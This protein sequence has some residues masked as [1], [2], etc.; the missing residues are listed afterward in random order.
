MVDF[1]ATNKDETKSEPISLD[2]LKKAMADAHPDHGGTNEAFIRARARYVAA[3]SGK[4]FYRARK[5]QKANSAKND[6][7]N[8]QERKQEAK[9]PKTGKQEEKKPTTKPHTFAH[10]KDIAIAAITIIGACILFFAV[11]NADITTTLPGGEGE[12]GNAHQQPQPTF[13]DRR[14]DVLQHS[15]WEAPWLNAFHRCD[16][17][18][19]VKDTESGVEIDHSQPATT[20]CSPTA[21]DELKT[22]AMLLEDDASDPNGHQFVGTAVWRTDRVAPGPGQAPELAIRADIEIP[23]QRISVK[24][25]L[26]RNDDKALPAS[27]TIEIVFTLPADFPHGSIANIPGVLMKQVESTRGIPLAG[28]AVKVTTN[29]FL[30]GLSSIDAD[31]QRNIQLLKERPWFD[32]PIVYGD[33]QRA[34]IAVEKGAPG[35]R[36]FAEAF[37]AWRFAPQ[38]YYWQAEIDI[39]PL[40]AQPPAAPLPLDSIVPLTPPPIEPP[41]TDSITPPKEEEKPVELNRPSGGVMPGTGGPFDSVGGLPLATSAPATTAPGSAMEPK[42]VKTVRIPTGEGVAPAPADGRP[43]AKAQPSQ[44]QVAEAAPHR[45]FPALAPWPDWSNSGL[46]PGPAAIVPSNSFEERAAGAGWP[47]V[48]WKPGAEPMSPAG[49]VSGIQHAPGSP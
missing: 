16:L 17:V 32:I 20:I 27:H 15:T 21:F 23:E 44:P 12:P 10:K 24:W 46:I 47:P 2:E 40:Q 13:D 37:A 5:S 34:L 29:F 4:K 36:V 26:R 8:K 48:R 33:G 42:R 43:P 39:Y 1:G 3:K 31:T 6:G 30:I 38:R 18:W 11:D 7:A 25:S 35:E 45:I 19:A 9:N 28:H 49:T 22:R 14:V 41:P